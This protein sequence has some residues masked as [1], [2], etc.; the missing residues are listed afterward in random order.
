MRFTDLDIIDRKRRHQPDER[1]QR[2]AHPQIPRSRSQVEKFAK[3]FRDGRPIPLMGKPGGATE[4][5]KA[6]GELAERLREQKRLEG[7][8]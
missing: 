6:W 7:G 8:A 4:R 2:P 5:S 1:P 3:L